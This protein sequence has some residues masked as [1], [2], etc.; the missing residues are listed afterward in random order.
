MAWDPNLYKN[1]LKQRKKVAIAL[2]SFIQV[3]GSTTLLTYHSCSPS[4]GHQ[5]VGILWNKNLIQEEEIKVETGYLPPFKNIFFVET[6]LELLLNCTE[7]IT[8]NPK[9][10]KKP[11]VVGDA[12]VH[13]T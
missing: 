6:K 3:A 1:L 11:P 9:K 5:K 4:S 10:L 2:K 7:A 13:F 8:S 12:P